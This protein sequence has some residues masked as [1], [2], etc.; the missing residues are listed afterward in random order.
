MTIFGVRCHHASLRHS[1]CVTYLRPV[2]SE[3]RN[4]QNTWG[5]NIRGA[6][7]EKKH[8]CQ[9]TLRAKIRSFSVSRISRSPFFD[10]KC[11]FPITEERQ[12]ARR[13]GFS[14]PD[15][16]FF[17]ARTP[18]PEVGGHVFSHRTE[19]R[20]PG[21]MYFPI[22]RKS[23]Y[24][25]ACLSPKN[26]LQVRRHPC[27]FPAAGSRT[28]RNMSCRKKIASDENSWGVALGS[29][30]KASSRECHSKPRQAV[31]GPAAA[32]TVRQRHRNHS[33]RRIDVEC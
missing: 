1:R 12:N 3:W 14:K 9:E 6:V 23:D 5:P 28:I 20:L 11:A 29:P 19:I 22:E 32:V 17:A 25:S 7:F 10:R 2:H 31:A 15:D 24:R 21:C 26:D 18:A 4:L 27:F 8:G 30:W 33:A 16:A 13:R